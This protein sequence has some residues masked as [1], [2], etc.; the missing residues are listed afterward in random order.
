MANENETK[1]KTTSES[2][3]KSVGDSEKL[4]SETIGLFKTEIESLKKEIA[5]LKE[6]ILPVGEK[7][8]LASINLEDFT[9][10]LDSKTNDLLANLII[11][12]SSNAVENLKDSKPKQTLSDILKFKGDK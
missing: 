2:D 8:R 7:E 1:T 11:K 4:I 5:D 6:G 9:K 3:N 10:T 12:A